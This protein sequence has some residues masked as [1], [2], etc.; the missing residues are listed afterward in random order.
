MEAKLTNDF[1]KGAI[2]AETESAKEKWG[3]NY[4][5]QHEAWAVLN[6]EIEEA[7]SELFKIG[8][9]QNVLWNFVKKTKQQGRHTK[10]S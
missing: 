2:A 6:E 9:V 4:H 3:N 1:I 8:N 5:S 10:D 7:S